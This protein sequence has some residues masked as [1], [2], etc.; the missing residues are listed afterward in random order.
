MSQDGGAPSAE[1]KAECCLFMVHQSRLS[2]I[3][4]TVRSVQGSINRPDSA[5][6]E[7]QPG[8]C[9]KSADK[10]DGPTS[11]YN[12][13]QG[14]RKEP[15]GGEASFH[16]NIRNLHSQAFHTYQRQLVCKAPILSLPHLCQP[17]SCTHSTQF[18]N[19]PP[20]KEL[21][22]CTKIAVWCFDVVHRSLLILHPLEAVRSLCTS[23]V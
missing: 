23:I 2:L 19:R 22:S 6:Q 3:M 10:E 18:H 1:L 5:L 13:L 4:A 15:A 14:R 16:S 7:G 20:K 8:Q 17:D 11:I 9:R 12:C 21:S